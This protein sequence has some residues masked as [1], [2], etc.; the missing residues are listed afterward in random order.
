MRRVKG[1][2][3]SLWVRMIHYHLPDLDLGMVDRT[4][5]FSG[6]ECKE[7]KEKGACQGGKDG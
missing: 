6:E 7:S 5:W 2:R 4:S 1:K 3:E